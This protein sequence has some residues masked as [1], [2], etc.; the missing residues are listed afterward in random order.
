MSETKFAE[1]HEWI[2]AD[3]KGN[4]TVGITS[5]AQEQLGDLVYVEAPEIG[6][7]LKKG[8]DAAVLES[9]KAAG[10]VKAPVSGIVLEFNAALASEPEKVNQDPMGEGWLFKMKI[11]DPAELAQLM[12]EPAY[13]NLTKS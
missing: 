2:R 11:S 4:A 5:Y 8:E 10:E 9:V 7:S 13:R 6:K 1:T 3:G 12:D